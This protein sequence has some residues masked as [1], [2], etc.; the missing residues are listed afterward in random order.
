MLEFLGA[1]WTFLAYA[2]VC[3]VGWWLVWGIYP[4]TA[5]LELEEIGALFETA[6]GVRE[7]VEGFKGRKR[8]MREER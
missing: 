4:E 5:G 7:S 1:S 2:V 6:W 8:R 3:C